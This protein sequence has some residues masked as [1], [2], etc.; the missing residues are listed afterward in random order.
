MKYVIIHDNRLDLPKI[1]EI[2]FYSIDYLLNNFDR[3]LSNTIVLGGLG[4]SPNSVKE[5]EI[6][7][8]QKELKVQIDCVESI[9]PLNY[10]IQ[11]LEFCLTHANQMNASLML[12]L[13]SLRQDYTDVQR[14][15]S[16]LESCMQMVEIPEVLTTHATPL[17]KQYVKLNS[18]KSLQRNSSV[19]VQKVPG[20]SDNLVSINLYISSIEASVKENASLYCKLVSQE[21]QEMIREWKV[22]LA[23]LEEGE[24]VFSLG[25][26]LSEYS[27]TLEFHLSLIS[28]KSSDSISLV[29]STP[30]LDESENLLS[31]EERLSSP[32]AM[33]V[34]KA[35]LPFGRLN[36]QEEQVLLPA[37]KGS[38][39]D[40]YY[41]LPSTVLAAAALQSSHFSE[42]HEY[43]AFQAQQ[44]SVL[45]HPSN[46]QLTSLF[47]PLPNKSLVK[48]V[49][50]A[51]EVASSKSPCIEFGVSFCP[52][53]PDLSKVSEH[54]IDGWFSVEPGEA[55]EVSFDNVNNM[56]MKGIL[57]STKT[58]GNV[59]VDF[60]YPLLKRLCFTLTKLEEK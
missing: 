4:S 35:T 50:I 43:V 27:E 14:K 40:I 23:Y 41:Q 56:A 2:T 5:M 46:V 54:M 37:Q 25:K 55:T 52:F 32:L 10:A 53:E 45:I 6:R 16:R 15:F 33:I 26:A 9:D 36:F 57:I 31:G 8:E 49:S 19:S 13:S 22:S 42:R 11:K 12:E 48:S 30:R 20:S 38:Y 39:S 28:D 47:V 1:P 29:L 44:K 34:K 59:S 24:V 60:S 51:V 18:N 3:C 58:K 17:T 21:T 7:L